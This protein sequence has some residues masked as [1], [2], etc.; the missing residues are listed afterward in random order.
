MHRQHEI[1]LKIPEN[2]LITAI[3][4]SGNVLRKFRF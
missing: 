1:R 3:F 2:K 4:T